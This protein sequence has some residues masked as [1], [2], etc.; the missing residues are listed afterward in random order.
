MVVVAGLR[1]ERVLAGD[2]ARARVCGAGRD[3]TN[4]NLSHLHRILPM[5]RQPCTNVYAVCQAKQQNCAPT[6]TP[7]GCILSGA[8][9]CC[10]AWPCPC[11]FECGALVVAPGRCA[12]CTVHHSCTALCTIRA[13]SLHVPALQRCVFCPLVQH[14]PVRRVSNPE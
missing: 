5:L 8:Q 11:L 13:L 10:L 14:A 9:F 4:I 3:G 2:C 6:S 7:S 1:L 12:L